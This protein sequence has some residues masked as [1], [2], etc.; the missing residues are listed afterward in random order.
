MSRLGYVLWA[1]TVLHPK[2]KLY[3]TPCFI[4]AAKSGWVKLGRVSVE[5]RKNRSEK[6]RERVSNSRAGRDGCNRLPRLFSSFA[7]T[8]SPG[9]SGRAHHLGISIEVVMGAP[10]TGAKCL[11]F[12]HPAPYDSFQETLPR[13]S[14]QVWLTAFSVIPRTHACLYLF[15]N[16]L[17]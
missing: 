11:V 12:Q 1:R 5:F 7:S 17:C 14:L 13:P 3:P 15:N 16:M 8:L 6:Q 4:L 2:R 9:I 10:T